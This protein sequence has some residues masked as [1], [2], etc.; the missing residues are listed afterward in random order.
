M[1]YTFWE[2]LDLLPPL[3]CRLLAR[4]RTPQGGTVAIGAEAIALSAGMSVTEVNSL[5]WL[6]SWESVPVD[7]ARRFSIA[8]GVDFTNRLIMKRQIAYIRRS[9]TFK[10]LKKSPDWNIVFKPMMIA[11]RK[12]NSR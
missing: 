8:C 2:K 12:H 1:R 9:P 4:K 6:T 5:S 11:F 7:K 10:Y 3:A